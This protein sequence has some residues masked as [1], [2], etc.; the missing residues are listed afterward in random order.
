MAN[1]YQIQQELYGIINA[2]EENDG[3][4]TPELMES[5]T[6]TQE[7]FKNKVKSYTD[8]IK[9][10]TNDIGAI[11]EETERLKALKESKEKTIKRLEKVII[12]AVEQFGDTTKSGG[13]FID[14]GTGKVSV[15]NSQSVETDDELIK[16]FVDR[17]IVGLKW[18]NDTNQLN[19]GI[20]DDKDL[21][22]FANSQSPEE[23]ENSYYRPTIN[24]SDLNELDLNFN[25]NINFNN[26]LKTDKG[27]QVAKALVNY[28][29][30]DVKGKLD[31][32][33]VK[34]DSDVNKHITNF[35][36]IILKKSLTIK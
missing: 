32:R 9:M 14:Y 21:I 6:I 16:A 4:L 33:A 11:K 3:E 31:K 19:Q 7:T 36:D 1:I 26:L 2:I 18:Y 29:T 23:E 5:F 35:A 20:I 25:I 34:T 28:G 24:E 30:F 12:E 8:V 22:D 13:K 10:L 27:F 17:Y 15:R